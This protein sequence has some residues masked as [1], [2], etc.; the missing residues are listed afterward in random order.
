M[1]NF[2]KKIIVLLILFSLIVLSFFSLADGYTD[3]FYVR[4]TTPRQSN[5]I[6]GTSRSAQGILPSILNQ[7]LHPTFFNFSFTVVHSPYGQVY[8]NKIKDKLNRSVKNQ[9]FILTVDPWSISSKSDDPNDF[10]SFRENDLSLG[11][12]KFINYKPNVEYLFENI[13][14]N[15]LDILN[16]SESEHDMFLHEDGWLEVSVNMSDSIVKK[17]IE[18]KVEIYKAKHLPAY[19]F[20]TLRYNKLKETILFLK[21]YGSVYLVRL[22]VHPNIFEIE[23]ELSPDFNLRMTDLKNYMD[24][25]INLIP[26]NNNYKYTD[27][28]HLHKSSGIKVSEHIANIIYKHQNKITKEDN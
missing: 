21:N 25:Y 20:S 3:P 16:F 9:I 22:P 4:F 12:T 10:K 8:L 19:K 11:K 2:L 28:N 7:K 6:L 18:S 23:N 17:R 14:G 26:V 27:G 15:Y 5:L 13:S 1:E 24:L